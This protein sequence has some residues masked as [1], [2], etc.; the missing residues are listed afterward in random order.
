MDALD[1][2]KQQRNNKTYDQNTYYHLRLRIYF[3]FGSTS[4]TFHK[5]LLKQSS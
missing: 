5:L 2:I 3:F 1:I 4:I